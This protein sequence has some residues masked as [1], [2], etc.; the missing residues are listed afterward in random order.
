MAMSAPSSRL[1][2]KSN[3]PRGRHVVGAIFKTTPWQVPQLVDGVESGTI[4]LITS[5]PSLSPHYQAY[6]AALNILDPDMFMLHERVRNWMDPSQPVVKG[7]ELHHLFPRAYQQNTL[8]TTDFKH[9]NQAANFAPTDWSTNI[10]ISDKPP[11][12]YW[13]RL[14]GE[15]SRDDQWLAD[16]MYFH[17]LPRGWEI[18]EYEEFLA[19]RRVR[20]ADVTR[21]AF[22]QMSSGKSDPLDNAG[23][24]REVH[25]PTLQDLFEAGLPKA[26][27]LLDPIDP[28]WV[29]EAVVSDDGTI[30]INGSE[31]FDN[32]DGAAEFL[33]VTN[34]GGYQFWA[35]ETDDELV[36]L[37]ELGAGHAR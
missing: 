2:P 17:A 31:V 16:Q 4:Q 24:V 23:E 29:V 27:D 12:E 30:V 28:E 25:E 20:V 36:P 32:L 34:I 37:S 14:V 33:D 9:I 18:M 13:P 11:M 5:G 35:L 26:G 1:N 15:R 22:N 10:L 7:T 3:C 6:L 19:E 8:G 21:D